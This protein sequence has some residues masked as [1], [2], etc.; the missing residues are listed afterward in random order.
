MDNLTIYADSVVEGDW[1]KRLSP[2][3]QDARERPIKGRGKNPPHVDGLVEYDR[4]DIILTHDGRPVLVLEKSREVPTGHNIGQRLARIVRSAEA[5]VP[6]VKFFPFDARKHGE[7][8]S[9][10]NLNARVLWAFHEMTNLH[11]VPVLAVNWPSDE[12]GELLNDGS[13]NDRVRE[14]VSGYLESDFAIRVDEF[15][16][17]LDR[18]EDEF[19]HRVEQHEPYKR[20]PP[21]VEIRDTEEVLSDFDEIVGQDV[22]DALVR[23]D[24]TVVYKIGMSPGSCRREDPYTGMQFLYDYIW[25]RSGPEVTDKHRNLVLHFPKIPGARWREANPNDPSRKSCNWYL[26][27]NALFYKDTS[28]LLRA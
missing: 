19:H 7:H 12:R 22:R 1:F 15:H 13:E 25:C 14:L 23:R 18:M 20:P 9:I 5:E 11:G 26:T 8:S 21:S 6:V 16:D 3:L 10:C 27:A 24:E 17:Q 28:D 4:P 2:V